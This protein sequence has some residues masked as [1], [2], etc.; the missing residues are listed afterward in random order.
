MV[1]SLDA[2]RLLVLL[3]VLDV[4]REYGGGRRLGRQAEERL[5]RRHQVPVAD[6]DVLQL[7]GYGDVERCAS[8]VIMRK[9]SD[10]EINVLFHYRACCL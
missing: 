7:L 2:Q 10:G 1:S 5:A 6:Q 8:V 4:V 9:M 3:H